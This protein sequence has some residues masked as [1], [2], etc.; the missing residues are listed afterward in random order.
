MV[1]LQVSLPEADSQ[2]VRKTKKVLKLPNHIVLMIKLPNVSIS[3]SSKFP[4]ILLQLY[5]FKDTLWVIEFVVVLEDFYS[6]LKEV[7]T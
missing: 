4:A 6:V 1:F 3:Q 2:V 7:K 5:I